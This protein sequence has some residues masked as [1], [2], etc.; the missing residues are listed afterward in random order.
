MEPYG[1]AL[2]VVKIV[3]CRKMTKEDEKDACCEWNDQ[4]YA[5]IFT[6]VRLIQP[7]EQGGRPGLFEVKDDKIVYV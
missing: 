6:D 4:K 7:F 3:D 1:K 2:C 5:W